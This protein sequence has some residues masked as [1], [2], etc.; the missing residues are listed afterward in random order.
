MIEDRDF[1]DDMSGV[2]LLMKEYTEKLR[3]VCDS[4][5][6]VRYRKIQL[7]VIFCIFV[8]S[9]MY[10]YFYLD[11]SDMLFV[12]KVN[13][14]NL[15]VLVFGASVPLLFALLAIFTPTS[16][17]SVYDAH[18]LASIVERLIRTVSQYNEHSNLGM[19]NRF[20]VDLRIAEA[21]AA[22]KIYYD[23]FRNKGFIRSLLP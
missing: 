1:E 4:Y 17:R 21:D 18:N 19:L 8:T 11:N 6:A 15:G 7:F 5:A 22:I 10:F 16:R 12:N 3:T 13:Y 9:A 2:L 23:V 20:E 14:E